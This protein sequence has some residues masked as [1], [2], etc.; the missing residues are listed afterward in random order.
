[1]SKQRF[2]TN[3]C[4]IMIRGKFLHAIALIP[5]SH[6]SNILT[7]IDDMVINDMTYKCQEK[8]DALQI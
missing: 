7:V 6:F 5:K 2:K 3:N 8:I 1:M 4:I